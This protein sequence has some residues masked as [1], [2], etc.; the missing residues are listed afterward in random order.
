M[1]ALNG[2]HQ[3][4]RTLVRLLRPNGKGGARTDDSGV[5]RFRPGLIAIQY[6]S[7]LT[8]S[9]QLRVASACQTPMV[10]P[11]FIVTDTL[12]QVPFSV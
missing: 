7:E 4:P 5:N 1:L 3:A 10:A 8:T 2:A 6:E 9:P 12:G 11:E